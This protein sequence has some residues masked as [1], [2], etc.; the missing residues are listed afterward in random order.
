M[1]RAGFRSGAGDGVRTR[2]PE[3]GKLVLYQLS[4]TRMPST[5]PVMPS[6]QSTFA[7]PVAG[8]VIE[9]CHYPPKL[10]RYRG[11]ASI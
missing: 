4:Y 3:L 9:I 1:S 8:L 5:Y 6:W 7:H 11:F 10:L 2:D